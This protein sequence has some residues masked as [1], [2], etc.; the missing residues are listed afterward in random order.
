M[1]VLWKWEFKNKIRTEYEKFRNEGIEILIKSEIAIKGLYS[2]IVPYIKQNNDNNL[3]P[4]AG[5]GRK[6]LLA[7]SIFDIL[8]N[9]SEET[10]INLFLI[11]EPENHLHRSMQISLSQI[12]FTNSKYKYLFV[13]TLHHLFFMKWMK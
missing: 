9:E 13:T 8:S 1:H 4:T 5:E 11:E 7:Y 3:Y 2:N 12:L 10:K 6:K